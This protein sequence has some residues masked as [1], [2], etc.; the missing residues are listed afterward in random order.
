MKSLKQ[1]L[2]IFWVTLSFIHSPLIFHRTY[3]QS[4]IRPNIFNSYL[5][6]D[7]LD[8][9]E[10]VFIIIDDWYLLIF[11][12]GLLHYTSWRVS[13]VRKA[14]RE[15]VGA[16]EIAIAAVLCGKTLFAFRIQSFLEFSNE[17]HIENVPI[18]YDFEKTW[19]HYK[20]KSVFPSFLWERAY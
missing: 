6:V 9:I 3:Y 10:H 2:S 13:K 14:R 19:V 17:N 11:T 4:W 18:T 20:T 12:V 1:R 16:I 5:L 15:N 8:E 7:C